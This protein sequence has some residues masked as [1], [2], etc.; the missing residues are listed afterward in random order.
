MTI[1]F[2]RL[3]QLDRIFLKQL[4]T[5]HKNSRDGQVS[6]KVVISVSNSGP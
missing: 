3:P 4:P 6:V 5:F 1:S 2:L